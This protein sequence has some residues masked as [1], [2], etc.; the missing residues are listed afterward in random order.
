MA[1]L[2]PRTPT[3]ERLAVMCVL[4]LLLA[5]VLGAANMKEGELAL[6]LRDLI[7]QSTLKNGAWTPNRTPELIDCTRFLWY[8]LPHLHDLPLR[9]VGMFTK[10][11]YW[12]RMEFL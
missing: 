2:K 1:G 7:L 3:E 11:H 8:A 4:P 5:G 10:T 6:Y 12:N 9:T